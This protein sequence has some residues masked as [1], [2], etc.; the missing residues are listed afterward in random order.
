MLLSDSGRE[1]P[2]LADRELLPLNV[3]LHCRTVVEKQNFVATGLMTR[4][5]GELFEIELNEFDLFELGETV[6]LTIYSPAGIQ[7]ISSIVFAKYDGVISLLQP[8]TLMKR[9]KEK[10]EHPRVQINGNAFVSHI[11]D[12]GQELI[13]PEPL[14]L[15]IQDISLSGLGFVGPDSPY[16]SRNSKLRAKVQIGFEF[17]CGLEVVRRDKQDDG[18][19]I[20]AKMDVSDQEVMRALRATILR[21]Q[22]EIHAD[23]R[24][25]GETKRF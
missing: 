16:F 19:L 4:V 5:E 17:S 8:P 13:L 2:E 11:V 24:R 9:F 21:Q 15:V 12:E 18:L 1:L 23:L 3:L 14:Q 22:V 7:T 25:K 20:G 10:R 6:K